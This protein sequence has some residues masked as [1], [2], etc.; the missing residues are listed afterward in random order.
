MKEIF[1]EFGTAIIAIVTG[2]LLIAILFGVSVS[3]KTGILEIAGIAAEKA[4]VDYTSYSDFE[5][6]NIWHNRTKP[7]VTYIAGFGRF[8][9]GE[10]A[11]FL[12]RYDAKD[13]ENVVYPMEQVILAKLFPDI[14]FGKVLDIRKA[15]G[16]SIM[17]AYSNTNGSIR[18]PSAGVY[19]V[20]F[21]I[22]DRENL[23]SIY[24][25]PIA[26]DAGRD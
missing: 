20:Y 14:M 4:E 23:T 24:Q 2:V 17:S 13:M 5:A 18:F 16:T 1:H 10:N 22:R 19:E 15:D 9:A 12:E 26:V 25:I 7:E 21:Q 8:F 11:D 3:G 6:V